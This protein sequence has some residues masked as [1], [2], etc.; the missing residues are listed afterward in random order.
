[1]G[2]LALGKALGVGRATVDRDLERL[3]KQCGVLIRRQTIN[4]EVRHVLCALPDSKLSV[5]PSQALALRLAR[6]VL[7]PFDGSQL[8]KELDALLK[9]LP[10]AVSPPISRGEVQR[11]PQ[12]M[13]SV[14]EQ[15]FEQGRRLAITYRA[16]S[17]EGKLSLH[18]V[19]ALAIRWVGDE[20]YLFGFSVQRASTRT[21][22][23]RR[24][25][26]CRLLSEPS[27]PHPEVDI[28]AEFAGA[29]KVWTGESVEVAVRI[30][31]KV[32][33]LVKE[34]RLHPSQTLEL[35]SSGSIVVRARV[36]GELEASRWILS[37]GMHAEVL[38]PASLR[39]R[40]RC[41][42]M[43]LSAVYT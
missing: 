35:D 22:K 7:V 8:T 18:T 13:V 20:L 23:F 43:G 15:A 39:E 19:D 16:A 4:G 33:W 10:F 24:V 36:N 1:M 5:S 25:E 28:D 6:S 32:A 21:F 12:K 29:V 42:V 31:P 41:E 17:Q 9:S 14:V 3:R 40:I 11:S 26:R 37:W 27:F 38:E 2:S 30:A 34:Y